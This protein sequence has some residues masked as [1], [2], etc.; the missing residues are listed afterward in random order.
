M[1]TLLPLGLLPPCPPSCLSVLQPSWLAISCILFPLLKSDLSDALIT[2]RLRPLWAAAA[3]RGWLV[4]ALAA[5]LEG[6]METVTVGS[7][8]ARA[9]LSL[10][11][12][13]FPFCSHF[14]FPFPIPF[15]FPFPFHFPLPSKWVVCPCS[16]FHP[17]FAV[18]QGSCPAGAG[19]WDTHG[20]LTV[21][22]SWEDAGSSHGSSRSASTPASRRWNSLSVQCP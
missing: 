18:G 16:T 19:Q 21:G 11:P 17:G 5:T 10:F 22:C 15:P 1:T 6:G 7:H 2:R 20:T 8:L 14:H 9:F 4:V 3:L 13:L 12:F